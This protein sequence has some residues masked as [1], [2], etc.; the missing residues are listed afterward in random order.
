MDERRR[1]ALAAT[2]VD[3]LAIQG[4][5]C[6]VAALGRAALLAGDANWAYLLLTIATARYNGDEGTV[7]IC[8]DLY[9]FGDDEPDDVG[10]R[11][12]LLPVERFGRDGGG[13]GEG[14]HP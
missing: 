9:S 6:P 11:P 4:A 5:S 12:H 8:V 2:M 13:A 7:A 10:D 1:A 3:Y 14:P